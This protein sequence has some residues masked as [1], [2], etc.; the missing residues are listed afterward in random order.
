MR[1]SNMAKKTIQTLVQWL[2]PDGKT[3]HEVGEITEID[4][5]RVSDLDDLIRIGTVTVIP[6]PEPKTEPRRRN[7][8]V[9]ED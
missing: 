7:S 9:E 2:E 1:A 8:A 6:E 5:N 3:W 4:T